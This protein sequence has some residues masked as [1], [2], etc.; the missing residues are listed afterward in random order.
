[1]RATPIVE[2]VNVLFITGL[3]LL[4]LSYVTTPDD[5]YIPNNWDYAYYVWE[6]LIL[7]LFYLC[8]LKLIRIRRVKIQIWVLAGF[9][10]IRLLWQIIEMIS[11]TFGKAELPLFVL[12]LL[13]LIIVFYLTIPPLIKQIHS[14]CRSPLK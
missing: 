5:G 4:Y 7:F 8:L 9:S 13:A 1:M 12:S 3:S 14:L 6:K 11:H 10:L 2:V